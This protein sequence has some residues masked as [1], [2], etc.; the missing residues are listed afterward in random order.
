MPVVL[1]DFVNGADIGMVEGRSGPRLAAKAFESFR[2]LGQVFRQELE[3]HQPA[4][5]DVFGFVHYA[6]AAAPQLFQDVVVRD[7]LANHGATV[8][9]CSDMLGPVEGRIKHRRTLG[10]SFS[11]LVRELAITLS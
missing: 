5:L 10:L 3:G 7:G 4:K 8:T 6:H 2:V 1:A 9:E 11:S